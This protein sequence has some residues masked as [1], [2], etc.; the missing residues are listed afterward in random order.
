VLSTFIPLSIVW[1]HDQLINGLN[2]FLALVIP[3][4]IIVCAIFFYRLLFKNFKKHISFTPD[5]LFTVGLFCY[6]IL[7]FIQQIYYGQSAINIHLHDTYF[8]VSYPKLFFLFSTGFAIFAAI[9]HWFHRLSGRQMNN[10]LGYI[11]FWLTFFGTCFLLWPMHYVPLAG[12]P[13]RYY[14]YSD[15][16]VFFRFHHKD[17]F[18]FISAFLLLVAQVLFVVNFCNSLFRKKR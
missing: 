14:D 17:I 11:H 16:T 2:P 3:P 5:V 1:I 13:R 4:F 7:I 9:Y 6:L 12:A 15:A 10:S 8:Q 18:I